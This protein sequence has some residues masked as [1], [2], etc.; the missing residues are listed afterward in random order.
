MLRNLIPQYD[1][2]YFVYGGAVHLGLDAFYKHDKDL[3]EAI[4][5]IMVS[6][7]YTPLMETEDHRNFG[8]VLQALTSYAETYEKD[9]MRILETNGKKWLETSYSFPLSIVETE[10]TVWEV[11]YNGRIDGIVEYGDK[12]ELFIVDH[13]CLSTKHKM[14]QK[15]YEYPNNQMAGYIF[16]GSM[17]LNQ[18]VHGVI[19][20]LVHSTTKHVEFDRAF[21]RYSREQLAEWLHNI[22]AISKRII[23]DTEHKEFIR[24]TTHC[25]GKYGRCMF[26][27]I[28]N[29]PSRIRESVIKMD[30]QELEWN[31]LTYGE[32]VTPE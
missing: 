3:A 20:N 22:R 8:K 6:D 1:K 14:W 16:T 21:I 26:Q 18:H 7:Y 24:Y 9:P 25:Y 12:N 13:K 15:Q 27:E 17:L 30:Y 11:I 29:A 4:N 32:T 2:P 23:H 19:V 31:P 10:D 5:A 28:C